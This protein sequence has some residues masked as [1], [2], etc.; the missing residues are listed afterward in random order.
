LRQMQR[1]ACVGQRPRISNRVKYSK[2]VPIH[3]DTLYTMLSLAFCKYYA[4]LP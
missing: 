2:L 4:E 3:S 1:I